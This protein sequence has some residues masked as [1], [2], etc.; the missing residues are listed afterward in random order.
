MVYLN[1]VIGASK[2]K[3]IFF[4]SSGHL[5]GRVSGSR[6]KM[7]KGNYKFSD[8]VENQYFIFQ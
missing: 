1:Q 8:L 5:T 6:L 7:I 4:I 3:Y 2:Y